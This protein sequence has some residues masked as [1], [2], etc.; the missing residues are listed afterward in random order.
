MRTLKAT[1]M[2]V[3]ASSLNYWGWLGWDRYKD[4]QPNGGETGP[5][6]AWQI[7]GCVVVLTAIV[8]YAARLGHPRLAVAVTTLT[9]TLSF[10]I[11][12]MTDPYNDGLWGVGAVLI[13]LACLI[14]T[15][16]VTLVTLSPQ[17]AAKAARL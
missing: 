8:A 7:I 12:G 17:L 9:T 13:L 11:T 10:S 1:V 6:Q 5:W 14:W 16:L 2:L 15:G 4:L 3:A